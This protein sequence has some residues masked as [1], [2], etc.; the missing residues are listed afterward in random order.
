MFGYVKI[1]KPELL[2]REYE[3]YKAVYCTLCKRIGK[4][5]GIISRMSLS[6]DFTFLAVLYMAVQGDCGG[7]KAGHC[8][9]NPLKRCNY[10]C[11]GD[12]AFNF[13]A[14]AEVISLYYKMC[15]SVE[16]SRGVKRLFCRALR[17]IYRRKFR[18]AVAAYPHICSVFEQLNLQQ[19]SVESS[20]TES[21]DTVCEPTAVAMSRLLELIGQNDSNRRILNRLGYCLGKWIYLADA[22][23]DYKKDLKRGNYNPLN[24]S[25]VDGVVALMNTASYEAGVAMELLPDNGYYGILKNIL[26]FGL[27]Q[28]TK[29]LKEKSEKQ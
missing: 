23:D 29:L 7:Y 4:Q 20:D 27:P 10:C 14:A 17:S 12:D 11:G 24:F 21:L 28:Q 26:F 1:D 5:Y 18:K 13:T 25:S 9:Y 3:Q 2:V 16:D 6:Y 15:D 19:S 8:V 22:L